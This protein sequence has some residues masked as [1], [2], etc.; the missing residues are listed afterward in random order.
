MYL[1]IVRGTK[2]LSFVDVAP[3]ASEN[4][5]RMLLKDSHWCIASDIK[6]FH[7]S[8]SACAKDLITLWLYRFINYLI[9]IALIEADVI[10]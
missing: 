5:T 1:P 6:K 9:W 4:L 2:D 3:L 7:A 8:I 10:G